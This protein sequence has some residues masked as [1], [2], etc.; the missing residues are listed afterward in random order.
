M[1]NRGHSSINDSTNNEINGN[2]V[3]ICHTFTIIY[4]ACICII[5]PVTL[6]SVGI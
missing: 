4:T 6:S 1:L 5:I 3:Q 2:T